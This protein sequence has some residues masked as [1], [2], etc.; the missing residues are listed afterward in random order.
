LACGQSKFRLFGKYKTGDVFDDEGTCFFLMH[1]KYPEPEPFYINATLLWF[2]VVP[3]SYQ[4]P[5]F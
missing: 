5:L 3:M 4:K 2:N 1:S